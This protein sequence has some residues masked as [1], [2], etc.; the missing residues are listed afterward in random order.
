MAVYRLVGRAAGGSAGGPQSTIQGLNALAGGIVITSKDPSLTRWGGDA[1]VLW[2]EYD[3]RTFSAAFGGP[4]IED[5]LGVRLS[6]ERRND[7][8]LIY[9]VTRDEYSDA[10]ES[11]NLRGKIKWTPK[12]IPGLEAV[13]SYNRVR[14]DGGYLYEYARTDAPN[15]F[16][17]RI[18]TG[19]QPSRGKIDN[20][21]AVFNLSYPL[22]QGLSAMSTP[23]SPTS[24]CPK[25]QAA[26]S[27]SPTPNSPMRR[28]GPCRAASTRNSVRASSP[29]STPITVRRSSPASARIR[30]STRSARGS[31]SRADHG[32]LGNRDD[33]ARLRPLR[34]A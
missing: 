27:N 30:A 3:D 13:A 10:L 4:I 1:R 31:G 7:R 12:A 18:A 23:N 25:G 24:S 22:A 9:N 6:A 28:A 34:P 5:E 29:I 32:Q 20:D 15:Y 33:S 26:R 21:L 2:T 16:H 14:R 11:L 8:R 17:H 19:D